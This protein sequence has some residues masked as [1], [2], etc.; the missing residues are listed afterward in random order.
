MQI[1]SCTRSCYN[2]LRP[3][4]ICGCSAIVSIAALARQCRLDAS[5]G[6]IGLEAALSAERRLVT[7][8]GAAQAL[9]STRLVGMLGDLFLLVVTL[10][11]VWP[12]RAGTSMGG[13]S[14]QVMRR[15][16]GQRCARYGPLGLPS[17]PG[18][19]LAVLQI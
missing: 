4:E 1:P 5:A 15:Q 17:A 10:K 9:G 18:R 19:P 14:V 8:A 3:A 2:A 16:V 12:G 7:T 11:G 13:P 6:N